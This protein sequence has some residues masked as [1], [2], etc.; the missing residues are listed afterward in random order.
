MIVDLV[1]SEKADDRDDKENGF[2]VHRGLSHRSHIMHISG[3]TSEP[4]AVQIASTSVLHAAIHAPFEPLSR[5]D[6][7]AHANNCSFDVSLFDIWGALSTGARIAVLH[8]MILLDLPLLKRHIAVQGVTVMAT[9]TAPLNLAATACPRVFA[10][11]RICFIGGEAANATLARHVQREDARHDAVSIGY[12]IGQ[13]R[14]LIADKTGREAAERELWIGGPGVSPGYLDDPKRNAAASI[15][16]KA[17]SAGLDDM[18]VRFY[19][20]GDIARRHED[21]QIDYIGRVDHQVKVRGFRADLAAVESALLQLGLF[22]EAVALQIKKIQQGTGSTLVAYVKPSAFHKAPGREE[23][24]QAKEILSKMIPD[25]MI[26]QHLEIITQIPLTSQAKVDRITLTNWFYAG[27][28]DAQASRFMQDI[29]TPWDIAIEHMR[30]GMGVTN[31]YG[32]G[33]VKRRAASDAIG[34][35]PLVPSAEDLYC[36]HLLAGAGWDIAFCWDICQHDRLALNL[37][38]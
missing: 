17:H 21:G 15:T 19:R 32:S 36:G 14:A 20:T 35:W 30:D 37:S 25:Y 11:L 4:K 8:K 26:P 16:V 3:T 9:T 34:G 23:V 38:G 2:P 7:V 33:Y 22:V 10:R 1:P 5:D 27:V 18:H 6:V 28:A 12:P 31:L 29:A 13:A 24:V